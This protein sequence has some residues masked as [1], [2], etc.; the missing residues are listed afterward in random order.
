MILEFDYVNYKG[1]AGHRRVQFEQ[2]RF[3]S[4]PWH[5][6]PQ[7][8]MQAFDLDKNETREF[9]LRD[10]KNIQEITNADDI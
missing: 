1:E 3:G 9:A 5:Q 2:V 10:M 6:E 7:W 4:S 8:L